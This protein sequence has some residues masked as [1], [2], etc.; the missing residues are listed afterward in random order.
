MS[1]VLIL[2]LLGGCTQPGDAHSAAA[3]SSLAVTR[4]TDTH[5]LFVELDAPVAAQPFA[6]HAHVTRM[7][8]NHAA[9]AGTL[10]FRFEQDGFAVESHADDAVARDGIF[11]RQAMAPGKPGEYRLVLAYADGAEWAEWDAGIVT[12]GAGV[13]HDHDGE[14]RGEI[15]FRKKAQWQVPFQIEPAAAR[16]L[17]PTISAAAIVR[18][19][20]G[21]TV[22]VAAP[23]EGLVAWSDALPVVGRTVARGERLATLVPASAAEHWARL[24]ADLGLAQATLARAEGLAEQDAASAPD[25]ARAQ[26]QVSAAQRRASAL[27]G[28]V[29]IRAPSDGVIVA[30]GAT[31]GAS[32]AAGVPL[33]S[34]SA[35]AGVLLEGRVHER[36]HT[37]LSPAT[38]LTVVRGDWDAP[39]D[40]L[41]AGGQLLT[42]RLI[43]DDTNLSA[44]VSVLVENDLGLVA[45][46]LVEVSIGVGSPGDLLAVP[47]SAVVEING[48][49]VVFVQETGESFSRRRVALGPTDATHVAIRSGLSA[50][51]M[52]V[53]QGG[54]DV[55]VASLSGAL[56]SHRH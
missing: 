23:V 9:S 55:H 52:V 25:L 12:V 37:H 1:A 36:T 4:W 50:G 47:R 40:L 20:P 10:T 51:E 16:P 3:E 39:R 43:F 29:P 32:I 17:S 8:D 49:D 44:P 38:S 33:V 5:E 46:D 48:Q 54:F 41:A 56:E 27:T 31:H 53:V 19:A 26:A 18:P 11:A 28:A 22:V 15:T 34:V 24:Q 2:A 42:E 6:Y 14:D 21:A 35:G 45:G 13:P 7:A 30:V